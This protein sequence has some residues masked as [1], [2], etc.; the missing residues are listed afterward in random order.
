METSS[1]FAPASITR[2]VGPT[3][4]DTET[5]SLTPS[6]SEAETKSNEGETGSE[7]QDNATPRSRQKRGPP[8]TQKKN[9]QES[10][11]DYS[12]ERAVTVLVPTVF[13]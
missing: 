9:D 12:P 10:D 11:P 2:H 13:M 6:Q 7:V 1:G 8:R 5:E 3:L 4:E